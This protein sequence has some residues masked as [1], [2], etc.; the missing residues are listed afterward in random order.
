LE[1]LGAKLAGLARRDALVGFAGRGFSEVWE[2]LDVGQ[3]RAVIQQ[4]I[5][6][7]TVYPAPKGRPPGWK[8]GPYF[9]PDCITIGWHYD[10]LPKLL[11][12]P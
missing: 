2:G 11:G 1:A 12:K 8:G 4:F 7:V 6:E 10:P 3:R 5:R 9:W